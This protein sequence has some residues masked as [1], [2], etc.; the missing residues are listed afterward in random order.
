[1]IRPRAILWLLA[2]GFAGFGAAY[3]CRPTA[4]AALTGIA[5]PSAAARV[6]FMATYGGF[7]LGFATFLATC[8][9]RPGWVRVGLLASGWALLGFVV[10][11]LLGILLNAGAV[12]ATIYTGLALEVCGAALAFWGSVL[13]TEHRNNP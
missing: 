9:V 7:Q 11:R 12:G 13:A 5:L 10:V 8:A 4:M 6:D 2:L 3:A 1:M